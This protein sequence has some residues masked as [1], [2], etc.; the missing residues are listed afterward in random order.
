MIERCA[1]CGADLA[2]VGRVHR[3]E[4]VKRMVEVISGAP[5]IEQLGRRKQVRAISD[6]G[7]CPVCAA[8]R[9]RKAAAMRR[10]RE[11]RE[12]KR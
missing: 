8:R 9:A 2:L 7:D 6:E 12:G 4:P 1:G 3:C 11:K 5:A 10:Y